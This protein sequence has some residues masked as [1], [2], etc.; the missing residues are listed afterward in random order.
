[1]GFLSNMTR[2]TAGLPRF[3]LE[4]SMSSAGQQTPAF[5]RTNPLHLIL[6][7]TDQ[8]GR[9]PVSLVAPLLVGIATMACS[10]WPPPSI[11][12]TTLAIT[13]V[14]G[15]IVTLGLLPIRG[16]SFGRPQASL[17]ALCLI[18]AVIM[19]ALGYGTRGA[20][21]LQPMPSHI[22]L[23][24]AG[25]AQVT[26]SGIVVYSTWIEP[27]RV[28]IS[29]MSLVSQRL[30]AA[31]SIRLLH[32][33]DF[34]IERITL[35]ERRLLDIV[36]Q[37][38]PDIVVLTGDYL[39][40]S[41]VFNRESQSDAHWLL[42]SVCDAVQCPVFAITGSPPV[43][44]GEVIPG[45]FHDLPISWLLDQT[46]QVTIRELELLIVGMTCTRQRCVDTARLR[47]LLQSADHRQTL[48]LLLYHSPDLMP[49]AAELGIDLYLCG[50]T[51]GGQIRLPWWGALV[52]SSDFGKR[53]EMG[54]YQE[55]RTTMYVSRGLGM[56]GW[57]APRA[58]F[59]SPPEVVLWTISGETPA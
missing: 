52:T 56:E 10:P 25:L 7:A 47:G 11:W 3:G 6:A 12:P 21:G 14:L 50:H 17:V 46:V 40:L 38:H 41:S 31:Q 55:K 27:F 33:T 59:L 4:P 8:L 57:G 28:G 39:N 2:P 58:R 53:Y 29:R 45:V 13:S 42:K 48:A 15:D 1:M 35:R 19:L 23:A 22:T 43:D 44:V 30:S 18:R 54:L 51:H 24:V 37:A 16:R 36:R 49:E 9:V 32:L 26:V 34:H 5:Y 20:L